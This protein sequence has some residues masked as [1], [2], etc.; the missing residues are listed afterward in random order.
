MLKH[1]TTALLALACLTTTAFAA[2]E[3]FVSLFNGKDI[4]GWV[5]RGGAATYK[6]EDGCIIGTCTPNTPDNTFLCLDK[7]FGN[8]IL[9]LEFKF[10]EVT[11]SGI[12]V[13]SHV[14]KEGSKERVYGYQC[15]LS[16]DNNVGRIYDEGRRGHQH[17]HV[18]LDEP[19]G[20]TLKV[21]DQVSPYLD[22]AAYEEYRNE[23][24]KAFKVN[25]WNEIEIQC[26]GPSIRTWINGKPVANIL[27]PADLSGFIGLQVHAGSKGVCAWRNIRIKD[28][29]KSEWYPFF[30][31]KGGEWKVREARY[32]VPSC[33]SFVKEG[34]ETFLLGK[35]ERGEERDGLV[36]TDKNYADFAARVTYRLYDGNSALY[37]RAEEVDTSWLLRGYQNE[38]ATDRERDSAIW[39]TQG[40]SAETQ[41]GRGWIARNDEYIK[42]VR[43]NGADDWNTICTVA[44]G[45]RIVEFMNNY[46]TSDLIDNKAET[47]GKLGLQLHGAADEKMNFKDYEYVEIT[48]GMRKLI[49]R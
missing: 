14:R 22:A 41:P 40:I 34:G 49:E 38:I 11:N 5:V 39:H 16:A 17:G 35:H 10:I 25:D 27:D 23:V 18:F 28:L 12:Q 47:T 37:F 19:T 13:R 30:V 7:E 33:W 8:F 26:V 46:K 44:V 29:G 36:V 1:I 9:K 43:N 20:A 3:G 4:D 21:D 2:E 42:E 6:V 24:A 15:E 48:P 45:N 31:K 32:V